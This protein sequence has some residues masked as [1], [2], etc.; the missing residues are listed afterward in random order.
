MAAPDLLDE[1]D[2]VPETIGATL[3]GAR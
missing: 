2:A 3:R 1:R